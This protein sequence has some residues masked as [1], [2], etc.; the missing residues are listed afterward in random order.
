MGDEELQKKAGMDKEWSDV[1][2]DIAESVNLGGPD[3]GET[4]KIIKSISV[5]WS[6]GAGEKTCG[7]ALVKLRN[8]DPD[9]FPYLWT[10]D[11]IE[12]INDLA[13]EVIE[14]LKAEFN[15]CEEYK[16]RIQKA[17]STAKKLGKDCIQYIT[18]FGF[19]VVHRKYGTAKRD[20]EVWNG[21][22]WIRPVAYRPTKPSWS[23]L[24]T[25][26]PA[27]FVHSLDAALIHGILALGMMTIDRGKDGKTV[28]MRQQELVDEQKNRFPIITIH[29]CFACHA[30]VAPEMQRMLLNG[31]ASMYRELDPLNIFLSTVENTELEPRNQATEWESWARNAFG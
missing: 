31:L 4:R 8:E 27:I 5:P 22:K 6:Y 19:H 11:S 21:E 13:G 20:D 28:A 7:D 10:L 14:V 1:Y 30:S 3:K 26:T 25:S 2:S 24:R 16:K 23:E 9:K 17:V 18:P 15:A 29:D 12:K